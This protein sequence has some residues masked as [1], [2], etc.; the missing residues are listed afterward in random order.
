M[1]MDWTRVIDI[2]EKSLIETGRNKADL[3]KVLGVR[4]QYLSDI[5]SG[6]SKN[7]GSDFA[8]ALINK[9]GFSSE[10]LETGEGDIFKDQDRA[11]ENTS[12]TEN[13]YKIPLLNQ[14]VSCGVGADW[15]SEQNIKGYIDIFS[16]IPSLKLERLFALPVQGN[17]MVGA[18]IKNGDYVLF[19]TEGGR[20]LKDD[21][22]VFSLDGE[23]FCK[24]LEFDKISKRIKIYS[25][26]AA[27]LEKAELLTTLD[28]E[29][30]GFY[31]RFHL[32][33][34]VYSWI[35]PNLN[36]V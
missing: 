28:M 36:D 16:L 27:D 22:Y 5:R 3:A 18:G 32:Y 4:S 9:M 25:V 20:S 12:K 15:E 24:L 31:D 33:G 11:L 26:R 34:R 2:A 35:H 7:P 19:S 13:S 14:R 30:D 17:S 21:I 29:A 23:V 10:W 6:K 8:L 1:M